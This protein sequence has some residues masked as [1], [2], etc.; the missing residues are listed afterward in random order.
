VAPLS[1]TG[2]KT[3]PFLALRASLRRVRQM[4]PL[5]GVRVLVI[6]AGAAA[7]TYLVTT[8]SNLGAGLIAGLTAMAILN[9]LID[10]K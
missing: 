7:I 3:V 9:Q 6:L 1:R 2:L 4:A 10:G 5:F 8:N